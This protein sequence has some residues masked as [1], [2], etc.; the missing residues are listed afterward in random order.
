M[1]YTSECEAC[2]TS[3][4]LSPE[5]IETLFGKTM[6]IK[7]VKTVSEE[8]YNRRMDLCRQCEALVYDTTCKHCGCIVQIKA[9]LEHARCP[10]PY[11]AKW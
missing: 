10:F 7:K 5:E 3:V 11:H 9:K 4:H 2:G 8:E 1:A 6:Q